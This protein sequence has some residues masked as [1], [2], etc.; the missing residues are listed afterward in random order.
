MPPRPRSSLIWNWPPRS[1][2]RARSSSSGMGGR[3]A[4]SEMRVPPQLG[5]TTASP[6]MLRAWQREQV[7]APKLRCQEVRSSGRVAPESGPAAAAAGPVARAGAPV[8]TEGRQGA[9]SRR[10]GNGHAR[11]APRGNGSA[12]ARGRPEVASHLY[13]QGVHAAR[14]GVGDT[15]LEHHGNS[16]DKT[17]G[18]LSDPDWRYS[19]GLELA[20]VVRQ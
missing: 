3:G 8:V 12:R 11:I 13:L 10:Y 17:A 2:F 14:V 20:E 6:G 1:R 7:M 5:H 9:Q 4:S 19:I 18:V 16:A 15:P